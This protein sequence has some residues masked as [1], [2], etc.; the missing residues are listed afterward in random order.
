MSFA[1]ILERDA[2][3]QTFVLIEGEKGS[4]HLTDDY[5]IRM[6]TAAGTKVVNADPVQYAWA[7]PDYA[8]VHSSIVDCN[9]DILQA[10]QGKGNAETSGADNFETVKLVWAA[11]A[12]HAANTVIDMKHFFIDQPV[13]ATV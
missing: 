6:T 13:N 9:R 2:F 8:V 11:Y 12:S 3:P 4:L 1:S 7:D 10:L 5:A